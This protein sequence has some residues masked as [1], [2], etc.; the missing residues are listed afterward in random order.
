MV[1]RRWSWPFPRHSSQSRYIAGRK[2]SACA[3]L[4]HG[5]AFCSC[6]GAE[7]GGWSTQRACASDG[8]GWRSRRVWP[9]EAGLSLALRLSCLLGVLARWRACRRR[10]AS[11]ANEQTSLYVPSLWPRRRGETVGTR[12]HVKA[13]QVISRRVP[14]NGSDVGWQR[15]RGPQGSWVGKRGALAT[16]GG[17]SGEA[18]DGRFALQDQAARDRSGHN[19]TG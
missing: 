12:T 6:G 17:R 13:P 8:Q 10:L 14:R 3:D 7:C 18:M 11:L 9:Q 16:A 15:S 1:W 19:E 4:D 2:S 5:W